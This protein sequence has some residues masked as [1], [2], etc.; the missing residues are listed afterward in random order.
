MKMTNFEVWGWGVPFP[1]EE[2]YINYKNA[3]FNVALIDTWGERYGSE[4]ANAIFALCDKLGLKAVPFAREDNAFFCFP[5]DTDKTDYMAFQSYDGA[6]LW[7]EA[8]EEELDILESFIP[9][10]ERK[11]PGKNFR[12]NMTPMYPHSKFRIPEIPNNYDRVRYT[13]RDISARMLD[14]LH[15]RKIFSMDDYPLFC[16]NGKNQPKHDCLWALEDCAMICKEKG[17]EFHVYLQSSGNTWTNPD[18]PNEYTREI[19]SVKDLR[20]QIL[21]SLAYG[22]TGF[23][24]F[25][26]TTNPCYVVSALCEQDG[27]RTEKYE[28]AK[29]VN[30]EFWKYTSI[31]EGYEWVKA[32][33]LKGSMTAHYTLTCL[34]KMKYNSTDFSAVKLENSQ[35]DVL[36]GELEKDGKYAYWVVNYTEPSEDT[37]NE[38]CLS[39]EGSPL[40]YKN[41]ELLYVPEKDG[42]YT[43]KLGTG[44][45]VFVQVL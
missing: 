20:F 45:G 37:Q 35:R 41:G 38:I 27:T 39:F 1:T 24:Y 2:N 42:K 16:V 17:Y 33:L 31:L 12:F 8:M 9:E 29:T 3:G 36:I 26:Y 7:D 43:L 5:K 10:F 19:T 18:D 14:K 25:I 23:G 40:F 22:V 4:K 32:G 34:T 11:N 13:L 44:E 15:G 21:C 28:W 6:F 30:G